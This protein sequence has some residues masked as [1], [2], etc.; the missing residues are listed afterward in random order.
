[1]LSGFKKT[2]LQA[3]VGSSG[4]QVVALV[5]SDLCGQ[6]AE[7]SARLIRFLVSKASFWVAKYQG[8][9]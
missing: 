8:L 9:P 4:F 5:L 3:S 1:M 7:E 2:K 6:N